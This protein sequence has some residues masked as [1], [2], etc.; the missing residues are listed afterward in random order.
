MENP[1]EKQILDIVTDY[2]FSSGDF[3][4]ITVSQLIKM[5]KLKY[6][7]IKKL[8]TKLIMSNEIALISSISEINPHIIRT[9]FREKKQQASELKKTNIDHTCLYPTPNTLKNRV[10]ID[11]YRDSPYKLELALGKP[12]LELCFFEL[13]TLEFYRN[14]PRYYYSCNDIGGSICIKDEHYHDV[15]LDDKDKVLL[16]A[17]GFAYDNE[18]NRYVTAFLCD[19]AKLSPEHQMI[20]KAK[21]VQKSLKVHPDFYGAQVLGIW[22]QHISIF[23][24]VLHEQRII[25]D[26]TEAMGKTFL[27][28]KTYGTFLEDKPIDFS[29][30]IRPTVQEFDSF[31]HLLDKLMSDNINKKFFKGDIPLEIEETR[32][33]GKILV[34]QK[35][36]ISLLDEWLRAH[37]KTSDWEPWIFAIGV[38]KKI[39]K[40]RQAPAHDITQ[41]EFNNKYAKDQRELMK[42]VYEA[43]TILRHALEGHPLCRGKDFDIPESLNSGKIWTM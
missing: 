14:D 22:P 1:Q 43:L 12:K 17:F 30:L 11:D 13:Q 9:G 41:N 4:G 6:Q 8:V 16:K 28:K 18:Q 35:G 29:F 37:Y 25:N 21:S 31:I 5:S 24:A 32:A 39:R 19:L 2:Y 26:M 42:E 3:N 23:D 7:D 38:F 33:D 15:E 20:W 10:V 34:T 40:K 36:T 27:F